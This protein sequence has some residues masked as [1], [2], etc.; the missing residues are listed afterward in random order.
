MREKSTHLGGSVR[1]LFRHSAIY[2]I[3]TS[4]QRLQG[5]ILTPIYTSS[6]YLPQLSQYGNYGLIYTFMAFMNFVY[7]YGMDSAF[8]RYF[9]LGRADRKAVFSTTFQ[10]LTLTGLLT[11]LLLLVF[12]EPIAGVVLF[13]EKLAVFVRLAAFILLFDTLGNLPF[14]V[15]RAEE[16]P[17]TFTVFRLL[18]FSLEL[19]LNIL[20]VVVLRKGVLGILYA[21]LIASVLNFF[22][23]T[24]FIVKYFRFSVSYRLIRE[25]LAFG[26]PF[27]PNGIAYMTIEMVDRFLVTRFLGKDVV[28]VYHA[29]FKFAT[30]LLLLIVGFRNAWQPFFL[31]IAREK[32]APYTYSRVLNYYLLVTGAIIILFTLFIENILTY[33]FFDAFY[34][35]GKRYWWGIPIIPWKLLAYFFFGIYIIFTPAFYIE[36]K[37]KYMIIFTGSGA[38]LNILMNVFFLPRYGIWA[39]VAASV[40]AYFT[41]AALIV[42]VAQRIYPIPI[43][44]KRILAIILTVGLVYFLYYIIHPG[45]A[46]KIAI[47]LFS[48]IGLGKFSLSAEERKNWKRILLRRTS[49]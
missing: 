6:L 42:V 8:L 37:S 29:N 7:L 35:L 11:S 4:V 13:S 20:F 33:R 1:R 17:V 41:M 34:L 2:S 38:L 19:G 46:W 18:R 36:K 47:A 30:V 22:I 49:I 9:F 24:P 39:A 43:Q 15:L 12:A 45:L 25:M 32:D 21:N 23:M 14:L 27:L 28:A 5:L 44:K 16:R 3:S 31:K 10:M 48:L 40:L 26:L